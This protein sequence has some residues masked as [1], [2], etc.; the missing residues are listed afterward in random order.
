METHDVWQTRDTTIKKLQEDIETLSQTD[1]TYQILRRI[2]AN[3]SDYIY[4]GYSPYDLE[5]ARKTIKQ[6]LQ[7]KLDSLQNFDDVLQHLGKDSEQPNKKVKLNECK[8]EYVPGRE[9]RFCKHCGTECQETVYTDE[10]SYSQT[11]ESAPAHKH[12]RYDPVAHFKKV[13]QRAMDSARRKP[14]AA[15]V[16]IVKEEIE[17]KNIQYVDPF[18]VH[19]I[20]KRRGLNEFYDMSI[21][22]SSIITDMPLTIFTDEM[23]AEFLKKFMEYLETLKEVPR[24]LAGWRSSRLN[25]QFVA[26][27]FFLQSDLPEYAVLFTV[28]QGPEHQRMYHK[29]WKFICKKRNWQFFETYS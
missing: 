8:C 27:Q 20:L 6:A 4:N 23:M 9:G 17:R 11:N 15:I 24:D 2:V 1:C 3:N 18:V 28:L 10:H 21:R 29:V 26:H 22:I 7:D 5:E 25:Y 13:L 16:Q 14:R 19:S 12:I